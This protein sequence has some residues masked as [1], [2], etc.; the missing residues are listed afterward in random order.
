MYYFIITVLFMVTSYTIFV[1]TPLAGP[2]FLALIMFPILFMTATLS[3]NHVLETTQAKI[4][5]IV[6]GSAIGFLCINLLSP[7][8]AAKGFKEEVLP[9]LHL[10]HDYLEELALFLQRTRATPTQ[11]FEK[12]MLIETTLTNQQGPY[13]EWV[14][15][16]GFNFGLRAGFR[17][18]LI[19]L[20]RI[21][22]VAFSMEYF[23]FSRIDPFL[24]ENL[25]PLLV[26]AMRNNQ[27]MITL[28]IHY[29]SNYPFQ[30]SEHH[31][32]EDIVALENALGQMLPHTLELIDISKSNLLI[33]GLVRNIRD[34]RELLLQLIMALPRE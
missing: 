5:D 31:F 10:L 18:F 2:H 15:E 34:M 20:E 16:V 33:V 14:Y 13:P 7:M 8:R 17:F 9:V 25:L 32:T 24:L 29:F 3:T 6:I 4:F 22:E 23:V 27:N 19:Q 26:T 1:S 28:M 12:K 30:N 21:I 11:L